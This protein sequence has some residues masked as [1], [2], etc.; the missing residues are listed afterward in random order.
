LLISVL[1]LV[2]IFPSISK[3][4]GSAWHLGILSNKQ[5]WG[6]ILLWLRIC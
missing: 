3:I 6:F 2:G 1:Q 4:H 5:S